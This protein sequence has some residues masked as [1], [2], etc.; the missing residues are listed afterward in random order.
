MF[1]TKKRL[2]KEINARL[3]EKLTSNSVGLELLSERQK[4]M[5]TRLLKVEEGFSDV[6]SLN[7]CLDRIVDRGLVKLE[8]SIDKK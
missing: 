3:D 2:Q 1:C 8:A 7:N 5:N 6:E 4:A